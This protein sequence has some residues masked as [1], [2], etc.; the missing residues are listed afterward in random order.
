[1]I[2]FAKGTVV[3]KCKSNVK[4]YYSQGSS[5]EK[6]FPTLASAVLTKYLG[7]NVIMTA[8]PEISSL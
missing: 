1:M 6:S 8:V 4:A 7:G 2:W 3:T 5:G